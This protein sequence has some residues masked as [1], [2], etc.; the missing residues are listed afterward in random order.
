MSEKV[1]KIEVLVKA[2][3]RIMLPSWLVIR[4]QIVCTWEMAEARESPWVSEWERVS[5]KESEAW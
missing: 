1:R 2:V 4:D 3:V 5:L